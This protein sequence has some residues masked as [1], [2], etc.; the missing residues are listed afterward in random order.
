VHAASRERSEPRA[1]RAASEASQQ[2]HNTLVVKAS[3]K[4]HT[5]VVTC[6]PAIPYTSCALTRPARQIS[7]H[8][9]RIANDPDHTEEEVA[10]A[11]NK[12]VK[13]L[14]ED[15]VLQLWVKYHLR[16]ST[17]GGFGYRRKVYNYKDDLRDGVSYG[18]MMK[19]VGKD[20]IVP[21]DG[22]MDEEIDPQGERANERRWLHPPTSTLS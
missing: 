14:P 5:L 17:R 16:R 19:R 4:H 9:K 18:V 6:S 21:E 7:W 11:M 3:Q 15:V 22:N 2:H 12:L 8:K 10:E 20:I 1:K 13:E